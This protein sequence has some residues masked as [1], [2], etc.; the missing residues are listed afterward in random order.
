M[1]AF[2]NMLADRIEK[3]LPPADAPHIPP[4]DIYRMVDIGSPVTT[5]HVLRMM[6]AAGRASSIIVK[7]RN[8]MP[9]KHWRKPK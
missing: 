3:C 5:R 2:Q 4:I 1:S 7:G 8:G 9:A 6:E